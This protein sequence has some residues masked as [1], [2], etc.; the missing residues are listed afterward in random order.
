MNQ[1][2]YED[3]VERIEELKTLSNEVPIIVEG[4]KDEKALR[5]LGVE[6]EIFRISSGMS[7][8]EFCEGISDRYSEVILLTDLDG[9]GERLARKLKNYLIHKGVKIYETFR[10][11]ILNK[12]ETHEVESINTRLMKVKEQKDFNRGLEDI[13]GIF[14]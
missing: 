13:D 11:D 10:K 12:L 9:E 5:S 3:L 2:K 7:L 1:N 8:Y 6:G 14:W 4:K